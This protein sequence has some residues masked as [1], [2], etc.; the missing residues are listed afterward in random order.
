[1]ARE[2]IHVTVDR[3]DDAIVHEFRFLRDGRRVTEVEI[4][5]ASARIIEAENE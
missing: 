1:M 5:A 3:H 2:L 4:D